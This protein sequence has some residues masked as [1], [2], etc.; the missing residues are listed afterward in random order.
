MINLKKKIIYFIF[1]F[2]NIILLFAKQSKIESNFINF[3]NYYY[4][5]NLYKNSK[6]DIP[7]LINKTYKLIKKNECVDIFY[8]DFLFNNKEELKNFIQ[9]STKNNIF[10]ENN[11]IYN[12]LVIKNNNI[13]NQKYMHLTDSHGSYDQ[14]FK[15]MFALE[16]K[17]NLINTGDFIDKDI[18]GYGSIINAIVIIAFQYYFYNNQNLKNGFICSCIGIHESIN[19]SLQYGKQFWAKLI[20]IT[21]DQESP[22]KLINSLKSILPHN[23]IIIN[24]VQKIIIDA[25]HSAGFEFIDSV[26]ENYKLENKIEIIKTKIQNEE[27]ENKKIYQNS[28]LKNISKYINISNKE[29]EKI[30]KIINTYI[31]FYKYRKYLKNEKTFF[32]LWT[33]AKKKNEFIEET[34]SINYKDSNIIKFILYSKY[35]ALNILKSNKFLNYKII[36]LI[37]H[38]NGHIKNFY[39]NGYIKPLLI[40]KNNVKEKLTSKNINDDLNNNFI[41]TILTNLCPFGNIYENIIKEKIKNYIFYFKIRKNCSLLIRYKDL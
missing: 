13:N 21:N 15:I 29:K 9:E 41:A 2:F 12:V 17:I 24:S 25:N 1:I 18:N 27:L 38:E 34:I 36:R 23:I 7:Y 11:N 16:N 37:G 26:V 35:L 20:E 5:S 3:S 39:S 33:D 31:K 32:S 10:K 8:E 40:R 28:I 6:L 14:I 30:T 19:I 4:N 22:K